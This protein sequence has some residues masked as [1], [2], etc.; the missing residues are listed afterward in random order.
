[1]KKDLN[2][3]ASN[4]VKAEVRLKLGTNSERGQ[5]HSGRMRK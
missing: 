4:Y 2:N 3:S 1:M 5:M